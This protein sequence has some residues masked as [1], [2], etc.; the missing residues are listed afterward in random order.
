MDRRKR[1]TGTESLTEAEK[2]LASDSFKRSCFNW[3]IGRET[4]TAPLF[5]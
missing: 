2:G 3:G 5:G 4:Y 1:D